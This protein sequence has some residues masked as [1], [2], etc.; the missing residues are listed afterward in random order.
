MQADNVM[1]TSAR[2]HLHGL[3]LVDLS[4]IPFSFLC[5]NANR[6]FVTVDSPT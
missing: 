3:Q 4:D 5:T 6:G 1:H 2:P